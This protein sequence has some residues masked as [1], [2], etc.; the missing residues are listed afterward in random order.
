MNPLTFITKSTIHKTSKVYPFSRII[1]TTIGSYSY[2]A[3]NCVIKNSEIGNFCSIALNVKIG[4][5]YHPLSRISSSPLF[6]SI[7]NPLNY[8]IVKKNSFEDTKNVYIGSDVWIGTGVV[9]LDGIRIENGAIIGAN[10]VV[11]K[12]VPPYTVVGGVP[13]KIIKQRFTQSII[14]RLMILK[15]WDW[16]KEFLFQESSVL[17]FFSSDLTSVNALDRMERDYRRFDK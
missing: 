1:N 16:K 5:G 11:T 15:W 2:I 9:I 4:L 12:N 17:S 14:D 3:Y 7:K 6:Y 13:A 10:S 8:S